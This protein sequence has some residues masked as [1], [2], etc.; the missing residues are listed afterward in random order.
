[1]KDFYGKDYKKMMIIPLIMLLPMLFL[2]FVFPGV[3]PGTDL[4]GGNVIIVRSESAITDIQIKDA[5]AEFSLPE[6]KVSTIAS[7][8]GFGAWI[9]YSKD[10]KVTQVEDL[11]SKAETSI[12]T[13]ADSIAFSNQAL[14]VLGKP[15]QQFANA[16]L[17]M[18]AAQDAL[19]AY[20]ENFSQKLQDTLTTK[21]SLGENAEF[22]KRE[23]SPTLG[24]ATMQSSIFMVLLGFVLIT[25]IVFISFRQFIPSVAIIQA[26]TFDVIAGV[27]GMA[28]LNIPL[29]LTTL[30]ALLM[31]IGYSVDTDIMLTSRVLKG[32]DGTPASRA[33]S[34]VLTGLTMSGTT[35][36]A[37]LAMLVISYFYQIEVIYQISAILLFGLIGDVISTWLMNG[38][39]LL[40]FMEKKEKG[41]FK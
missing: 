40:W 5:L 8:T 1:M 7:P 30:P 20:K 23:V 15:E 22:Q 12:D 16:K 6:L 10:P 4:T 19:A 35:I 28:I 38:P 13:D 11:L 36:V 32:K 3:S 26:M 25:I 17:A 31:L 37:L 34:S 29:S 18:I 33:S 24:G 39:I 14:I 27:A 21:L 9:S 2:I 41:E